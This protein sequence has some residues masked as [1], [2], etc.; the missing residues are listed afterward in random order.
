MGTPFAPFLYV[1]GGLFKTW[2]INPH[3]QIGLDECL[4]ETSVGTPTPLPENWQER[5][6]CDT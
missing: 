3:S 2:Y 1:V 4:T 5:L 6:I